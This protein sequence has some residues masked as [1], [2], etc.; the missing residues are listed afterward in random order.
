MNKK[1]KRKDPNQT[2]NCKYIVLNGQFELRVKRP[3]H[4]RHSISGHSVFMYSVLNHPSIT[5]TRLY[6]RYIVVHLLIQLCRVQ[7]SEEAYEHCSRRQYIVQRQICIGNKSTNGIN[8]KMKI[9]DT[10]PAVTKWVINPE[11]GSIWG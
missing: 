11:R 3:Y 4:N 2:R 10:W 9:S 1:R 8:H 5:R 6:S 7:D